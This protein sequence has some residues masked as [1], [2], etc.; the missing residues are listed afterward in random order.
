MLLGCASLTRGGACV[1]DVSATSEPDASESISRMQA[2]MLAPTTWFVGASGLAGLSRDEHRWLDS[3]GHGTPL[4]ARLHGP[5]LQRQSFEAG[6]SA[7]MHFYGSGG[8]QYLDAPSPECFRHLHDAGGSTVLMMMVVRGVSARQTLLSSYGRDSRSGPGILYQ[9]D[10]GRQAVE[11]SWSAGGRLSGAGVSSERSVPLGR[12][13]L[14]TVRTDSARRR[15]DVRVNGAAQG[16]GPWVQASSNDSAYPLRM[17]ATV[18]ET[19]A[20][21]DAD[22]L[23][24]VTYSRTLS[25]LELA[26]VEPLILSRY[27]PIPT[28]PTRAPLVLM[29]R[30]PLQGTVRV[31]PIGDS[32]TLGTT[33]ALT[34]IGGW[35]HR[36]NELRATLPFVLDFVGTQEYGD[37]ADNQHESRSGWVIDNRLA[38]AQLRGATVGSSNQGTVEDTLSQLNPPLA[39][40]I[41][42]LMLGINSLTAGDDRTVLSRDAL[43]DYHQLVLEIHERRPDARVVVVPLTLTTGIELREVRRQN[44]NRGLGAVVRS[45][46]ALGVPL[47]IADTE[48]LF[49][50]E[51]LADGLHPNDSGFQKLGDRILQAI[52]FA[53]GHP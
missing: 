42:V 37:F 17:G 29:A 33:G 8:A 14:L 43:S 32:I 45:L 18:P 48:D 15:W 31:L 30:E 12:P 2:A 6:G 7:A 3:S 38:S 16:D 49:A 19:V 39:V 35:R 23:E 26:Q 36:V 9:Y 20:A 13:S 53:A 10:P 27:D 11:L 50:A 28:T 44:F 5:D 34:R 41:V 4:I 40:D 47:A 51:D 24:F 25:D 46:R 21:M 22:I 1:H 52:R